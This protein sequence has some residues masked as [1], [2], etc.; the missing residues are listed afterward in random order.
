LASREGED[1]AVDVP[2]RVEAGVL[3]K[4]GGFAVDGD[5]VG[6]VK[7]RRSKVA[8]TQ[9]VEAHLR[10]RE[11]VGRHDGEA[12]FRGSRRGEKGGGDRAGDQ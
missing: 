8:R 7:E 11:R 5:L 3:Q 4:G 6:L 2:L 10:D 1:R 12:G 9:L